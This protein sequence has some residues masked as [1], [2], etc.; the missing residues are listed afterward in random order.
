MPS[1]CFFSLQNLGDQGN[2]PRNRK[3]AFYVLQGV[4]AVN[5]T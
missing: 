5:P 1:G 3:R 4:P 2:P